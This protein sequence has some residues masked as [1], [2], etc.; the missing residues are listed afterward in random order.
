MGAKFQLIAVDDSEHTIFD[1]R[2][3]AAKQ[4]LPEVKEATT[5]EAGLELIEKFRPEP[6]P[7]VFLIDLKL[8]DEG[9]G[10]RILE[11]IRKKRSL[12][13]APVIILTSSEDQAAINRSYQLGANSYVIKEGDPKE[14]SKVLDDLISYWTDASMHDRAVTKRRPRK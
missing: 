3:A 6:V 10:F 13:Y 2:E 1:I 5:E 7:P 8:R 14:F 9:S 12:R 11:A 4:D